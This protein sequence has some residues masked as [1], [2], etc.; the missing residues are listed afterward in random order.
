MK[1]T[2]DMTS[3]FTKTFS[4]HVEIRNYFCLFKNWV[5]NLQMVMDLAKYKTYIEIEPFRFLI[6]NKLD[7]R[8]FDFLWLNWKLIFFP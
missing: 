2:L 8:L 6:V 4:N 3:T 7:T 5:L 1:V